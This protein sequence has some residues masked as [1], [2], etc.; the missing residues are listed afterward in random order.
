MTYMMIMDFFFLVHLQLKLCISVPTVYNNNNIY[1]AQIPY[2]DQMGMAR[3]KT[4][5][6]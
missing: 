6:M 2:N 1:N 5:Y 3:L 4:E